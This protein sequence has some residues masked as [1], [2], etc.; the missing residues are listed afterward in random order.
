M[1]INTKI[2]Q[3][4]DITISRI[5][6]GEVIERPSSV[7]KELVEN[8]IDAGATKI[9]ITLET[10]GKNLIIVSDNGSGMTQDDL[11]LCVQRH[12]TSKLREDDIMDIQS[13]GFRGEA[14]PSIGSISRLSITTYD[15]TA[16]QGYQ[17]L[18]E[19][20][21]VSNLASVLHNLGTRVEVRDLFFAT[22]ARLKFL[23]SDRTELNACI[24]VVKKIAMSSSNVAFNLMHDDKS[25]LKLRQSSLEERVNELLG[26]EFIE[27]STEVFLHRDDIT[28]RGF[29]SVPTFHRATAED[30]YLFV[31]E[32]SVKD[33]LINTSVRVAYQDFV[34]S[35]RYPVVVLFIDMNPKLVDVN[36]HP[37]KAEVRFHDTS[38]I[39]GLVISAIRDA[40][41]NV[42]HKVSTTTATRA[43]NY[44]IKED[45]NALNTKVSDIT[46]EYKSNLYYPLSSEGK[47]N[48]IS[49]PHLRVTEVLNERQDWVPNAIEEISYPLGAAATQFNKTY[50][51][52]QT[53]DSIIITDQH[54]A[55]E[56]ITYEALKVQIAN[57]KV[58]RQRLLIPEIIKLPD[59]KRIDAIHENKSYL[60]ECGLIFEEFGENSIIVNEVPAMLETANITNLIN[61]IADNLVSFGEEISF[62]KLLET[63][64]ETYACHNSIRAGRVM[65]FSEMNALLRQI[66]NTPFSGQCNHGRPTYIELKL[67]DIEKLFGRK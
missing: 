65:N 18:V 61:D 41:S 37:S 21:E 64:I 30:Q 46:S 67:K 39:R 58:I 14:L 17:I 24:D 11:E 10:S 8:A 53:E 36:V 47:K 45:V 22:P 25:L 34:A 54:A 52:S 12:T 63:I 59:Q 6:A 7:I 16:S 5:A 62:A 55:H 50:I 3:L 19:G 35:G 38:M 4:S 15:N 26:L 2:K 28:I 29:V 51:I 20:G 31:N 33:K 23:R 44:F 49:A 40:L 48:S 43:I 56:R 1:Q 27:N 57:N 42:S 9:D 32:R 66:E 60:A 13:F